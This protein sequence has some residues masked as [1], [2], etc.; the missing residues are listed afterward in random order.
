MTIIGCATIKDYENLGFSLLLNLI[1]PLSAPTGAV[2]T[3][4]LPV[5]GNRSAKD[6][7]IFLTPAAQNGNQLWQISSSAARCIL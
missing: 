3:C 1:F 2:Q 5:S 6:P 4:I 7:V